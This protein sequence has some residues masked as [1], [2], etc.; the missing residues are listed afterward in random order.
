[1]KQ[2]IFIFILMAILFVG[3]N[4]DEVVPV[5]ALSIEGLKVNASYTTADITWNIQ[6]KATIDAVVLE[7]SKDSTFMTFDDVRMLPV[8]KTPNQYSVVLNSLSNGTRYFIRCRAINKINSDISESGTF[9]TLAYSLA[10]VRTD[11][12]TDIDVSSA[13]LHATLENSGTDEKL[14]FGFYIAT[15]RGITIE[16]SCLLIQK[17]SINDSLHFSY[18]VSELE[19]NVT[20]YIRAFAENIK[21]IAWGEELAFTTTE[22]FPPSVGATVLKYVSY[23]NA[24]FTSEVFSD[25]GGTILERGFCYSTSP[26]PTIESNKITNEGGVGSYS[27]YISDLAAS[28]KYYV[29]AYAINSKG[30]TYGEQMEFTTKDYTLPIVVTSEV[31]S[32]KYTTA[33]CRG[34]VTD[35][36]GKSVIARGFCY[37]ISPNPTILDNVI[38]SGNGI[39]VFSCTLSNLVEGKTYHVRAFATN[40]MGTS[41]GEVI[42]F[43]TSQ[44]LAN[45]IYYTATQK[46]NET[47]NNT[48][49]GLHIY[50]F[51][52]SIISHTFEVGDD[53]VGEGVITF[54]NLLTSIGDHAFYGSNDLFSVVL[55]NS[56]TSIGSS[57]FYNCGNLSNINIP[58]G[59]TEIGYTAFQGCRNLSSLVLPTS[60]TNI[61][62]SAFC[63]SGLA[64]IEIPS[65]MTSI[66]SNL[67]NG[68]SSLATVIIPGSV[69]SIEFQAFKEC[70]SLKTIKI[71]EGTTT[72]GRYA[73]HNCSGANQLV[74]SSTV[75]SI[76]ERAFQG[77]SGLNSI[78]SKAIT[79]PSCYN[80]QPYVFSGVSR[81]TLLYVPAASISKYQSAYV[82]GEFYNIFPISE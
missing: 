17:E 34:E 36:G 37:S 76:G 67:F 1:M 46:L 18:A 81:A 43:T 35:D 4:E 22:M 47:S 73:F 23:T 63:N 40:D 50:R 2:K 79:P 54:E 27:S 82:W 51:N 20:Y 61:G 10:D 30:S 66:A 6:S 52:S 25:G 58:D 65:G 19:D 56:V 80:N 69:T 74:L 38:K 49:P 13:I 21:G 41:Y 72:I 78:T 75:K 26:N 12:I 53:G 59:V 8:D 45:A 68:C 3:C 7:Y 60:V 71:P 9:N 64:S 28:T 39:G 15:H 48:S 24:I 44:H 29:R 14:S 42:E 31:S 70:T 33:V 16:D 11:T 57:A 55:P 32:I 5:A 77:C 62:E